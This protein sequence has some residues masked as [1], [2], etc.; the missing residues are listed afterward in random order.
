MTHY[1]KITQYDSQTGSGMIAPLEGGDALPF[2]ASGMAQQPRSDQTYTYDTQMS[3]SGQPQAIN[4]QMDPDATTHPQD[5]VA[6]GQQGGF[7]RQGMSEEQR[8]QDAASRPGVDEQTQFRNPDRGDLEGV[9]RTG[10][11]QPQSQP[12]TNPAGGST[13]QPLQSQ[14]SKTHPDPDD[15]HRLGRDAQGRSEREQNDP[16][17]GTPR[18]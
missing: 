3:A 12:G 10:R 11:D 4:L 8:N 2:N 13:F 18:R 9:S 5:A 7:D 6:P 17:R 1:G 15:Q 14:A 16:G